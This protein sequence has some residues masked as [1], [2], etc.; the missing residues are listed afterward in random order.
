MGSVDDV[1]QLLEEAE[2]VAGFLVN[3]L[4]GL[5]RVENQKDQFEM[6][7]LAATVRRDESDVSRFLKWR[8]RHPWVSTMSLF[9]RYSVPTFILRFPEGAKQHLPHHPLTQYCVTPQIDE[10]GTG[11]LDP[12]CVRGYLDAFVDLDPMSEVESQGPIW[13]LMPRPALGEEASDS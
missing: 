11:I 8:V 4:G 12:D 13:S 1:G 2:K 5:T 7:D 3:E 10:F 6:S 9:S